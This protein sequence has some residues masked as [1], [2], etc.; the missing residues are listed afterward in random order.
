MTSTQETAI[1]NET[2]WDGRVVTNLLTRLSFKQCIEYLMNGYIRTNSTTVQFDRYPSTIQEMSMQYLGNNFFIRFKS[3]FTD[4][5]K[6]KLINEH[7]AMV[8][9]DNISSDGDMIN[10]SLL[11]DLPIPANDDTFKI[12]WNVKFNVRSLPNGHYFIGIAGDKFNHFD[13]TMWYAMASYE[14]GIFGICCNPIWDK[15]LQQTGDADVFVWNSKHMHDH[16]TVRKNF[17]TGT[18][19]LENDEIICC[20]YDGSKKELKM[21]K[22]QSNEL[23]FAA[24]LISN[25]ELK[26]WYPVISLR[27]ENDIIEIVRVCE[28]DC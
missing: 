16:Q 24:K 15:E 7:T 11:I 28:N 5:T 21:I 2:E 6:I 17:E 27:D 18:I 22:L 4:T 13:N 23:L 20:E 10:T 3:S 8:I 19:N 26:Y 25:D 1:C 9:K 14:P 12:K